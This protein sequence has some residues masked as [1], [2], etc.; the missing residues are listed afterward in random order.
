[1]ENIF[2]IYIRNKKKLPIVVRR[3][4]WN[5]KFAIA[6]IRVKTKPPTD[7]GIYGKAWGFSLPPLDG[8]PLNSYY[9]TPG[10]PQEISCAGCY[11][12]E[13]V[14]DLPIEWIGI[15]DDNLAA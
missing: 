12:W 1:M 5:K 10:K 14:D 3:K 8:T 7:N 4:N 6:V 15:I 2:E 13:E 9:G 11:Q